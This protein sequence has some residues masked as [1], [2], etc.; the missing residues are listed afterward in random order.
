[1]LLWRRLEHDFL[2]CF[3][4]LLPTFRF[5][6]LFSYFF[7]ASRY[8][9]LLR[10]PSSVQQPPPTLASTYFLPRVLSACVIRTPPHLG[11]FLFFYS[12]GIIFFVALIS[13]VV[14]F[15][16]CSRTRYAS[17]WFAYLDSLAL[18]FSLS[19]CLW[20]QNLYLSRMK[21]QEGYWGYCWCRWVERTVSCEDNNNIW[22]VVNAHIMPCFILVVLPRFLPA[23][24]GLHTTC[25]WQVVTL[26]QGWKS[27]PNKTVYSNFTRFW[28]IKHSLVYSYYTVSAKLI[29]SNTFASSQAVIYLGFR[30]KINRTRP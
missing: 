11:I 10:V 12:S 28:R 3:C 7:P 26:C 25:T 24:Q 30:G 16:L 8:A 29:R 21:N 20:P 22:F 4:A 27:P 23:K 19:H 17:T 13:R 6:F 2:A 5:S 1:M 15:L 9:Y 18:G 14:F